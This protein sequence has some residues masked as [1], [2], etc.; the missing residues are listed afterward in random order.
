LK[1]TKRSIWEL[2]RISLIILAG[3]ALLAF[4]IAAFIIPHDIATGGATGIGIALGRVLPLP[5]SVI[6]LILY[7][8]FLVF[9]GIV[10]GK[11]FFL[12]TVASS[13]LYPVFLGIFEEIPALATLTDNALL[14]AL[15]AGCLMGISL[16]MLMRVGSST[17]G[18]DALN[19]ALHKWFPHI[20]VSVF[21][22]LTD[23]VI[24]FVQ[25]LFCRPE[26]TM[27]GILTL[28]IESLVLEQVMVLGKSQIQIFAVSEKYDEIR[29]EILN[30]NQAGVTMT[31]IETGYFLQPQKGVMCVVPPRK[32]Y[33]V[34]ETIHRIDPLAFVTITKI[35]EVRGR[36]FTL[37]R[38]YP[39]EEKPT[40]KHRG[41]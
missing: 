10:L 21:V 3:N 26:L 39:T 16:G 31:Q 9:G 25:A 22:Y 2:W 13:I 24:I 35:K 40:A 4:A 14:A 19:L 6:V 20:S 5:N 23:T 29:Q 34:T 12:T 38:V 11:K 28:L 17:G 37:D 41:D 18:T 8:A 33:D 30:T 15:F 27:L 7:I 1:Q 32:V 36:G